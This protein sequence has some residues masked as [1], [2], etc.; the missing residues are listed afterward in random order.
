MTTKNVLLDCVQMSTLRRDEMR[1]VLSRNVLSVAVDPFGCPTQRLTF[2]SRETRIT[3]F[4]LNTTTPQPQPF[5][6]PFSGTTRV[7]RCQKRT[8]GFYGTRED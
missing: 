3:V 8:S 5:Y 7:S 6:G 1:T 2:W 4:T